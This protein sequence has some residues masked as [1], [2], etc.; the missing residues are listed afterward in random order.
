MSSSPVMPTWTWKFGWAP[1]WVLSGC[2]T[3]PE[4]ENAALAGAAKN[5]NPT[6]TNGNAIQRLAAIFAGIQPLLP[7]IRLLKITSAEP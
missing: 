3:N 1:A 6:M 4:S 2:A 7:L 5:S